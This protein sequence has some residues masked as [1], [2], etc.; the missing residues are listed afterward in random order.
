VVEPELATGALAWR[1]LPGPR[2]VRQWTAILNPHRE[3]TPAEETLIELCR[4]A[5]K[6]LIPEP[7][8]R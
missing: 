6:D 5:A 4:A 7:A 3:I 1:P 2:L 8:G